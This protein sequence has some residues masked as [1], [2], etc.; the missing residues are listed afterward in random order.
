[1]AIEAMVAAPIVALGLMSPGG[2]ETFGK[3]DNAIMLMLN[4]FLRPPLMIIGFITSIMFSYISIWLL[5]TGFARVSNGLS[6]Y[7]FGLPRLLVAPLLIIVIY[8]SL[9]T[10]L[11]QKS[12]QLIHILPD[13]VLRWI[14]GGMQEAFGAGDTASAAMGETKGAVTLGDLAKVSANLRW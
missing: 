12:F 5:N 7:M 2:S 9:F 6:D 3:A 4:V 14:G 1:M 13:K 10:V 8:V 11:V